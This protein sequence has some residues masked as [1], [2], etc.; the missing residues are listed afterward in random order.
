MEVWTEKNQNQ[1]Q[2]TAEKITQDQYQ[3]DDNHEEYS[4][5]LPCG[6]RHNCMV[7]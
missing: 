3:T 1:S 2:L 5:H 7:R 6:G 4:N